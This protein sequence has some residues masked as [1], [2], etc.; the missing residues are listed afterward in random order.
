MTDEELYKL[1]LQENWEDVI[2]F[3][4]FKKMFKASLEQEQK[5][6]SNRQ[7]DKRSLQEQE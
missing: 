6:K 3:H 2:T 7:E 4:R 1:Y 5:S